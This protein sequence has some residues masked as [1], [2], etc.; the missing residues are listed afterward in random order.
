MK[1]IIDIDVLKEEGFDEVVE[2]IECYGELLED[3]REMDRKEEERPQGKWVRNGVGSFK[4]SLCG[5]GIATSIS[6]EKPSKN[7]PYCH[8]GAYMGGNIK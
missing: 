7:Y 6:E 3:M 2:I 1:Y 4:C 8:C 5:R